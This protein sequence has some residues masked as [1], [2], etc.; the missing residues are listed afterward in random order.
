[1]MVVVVVMVMMLDR[2]LTLVTRRWPGRRIS[3]VCF[4]SHNMHCT[5]FAA[6]FG[7]FDKDNEGS[8]RGNDS[9]FDQ[10]FKDA[11]LEFVVLHASLLTLACT[12]VNTYMH[13]DFQRNS[14]F[15]LRRNDIRTI[16]IEARV[17]VR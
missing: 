15:L 7:L 10:D 5:H 6:L 16:Y 2:R 12:F 13:I 4:R 14:S 9:D 8:D 1:M 17:H 11:E 3:T